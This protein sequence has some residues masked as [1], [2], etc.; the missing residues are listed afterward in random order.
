MHCDEPL[1]TMII[2]VSTMFLEFLKILC[3]H[4]V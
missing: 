4:Y 1:V 3:G 2:A